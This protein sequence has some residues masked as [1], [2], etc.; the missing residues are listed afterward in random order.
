MPQAP[1]GQALL[2]AIVNSAQDFAIIATDLD[3]LITYWS[4]GA[5]QLLGW[6]ESE[7]IGLPSRVFF[8]PEDREAGRPQVEMELALCDGRAADERWHQRRD[9]SQF[10]GQ[11][12]TQPLMAGGGATIGFL[13]ILRDRTEQYL[14]QQLALMHDMP[15]AGPDSATDQPAR[16]A[17]L[18]LDLHGRIKYMSE[19][20][21]RVVGVSEVSEHVDQ[22]WSEWWSEP[23]RQELQHAVERA[24]QGC[25]GH[26]EGLINRAEGGPCWWEV[27]LLPSLNA[28]GEPE[29]IIAL[30]QDV[31]YDRL[32]LGER[33][34]QPRTH[35]SVESID[36]V[37]WIAQA[38][39]EIASGQ[40]GWEAL[41]GQTFEQYQGLGWIS[42]IHPAD[43]DQWQ[44]A[45]R[46]AAAERRA[47]RIECR[48]RRRDD[49]WSLFSVSATPQLDE[50]QT[51][52]AWIIALHD[53][54][55]HRAIR[56]ALSLETRRLSIINRVGARLAAELDLDRLVQEATDAGVA[57]TAAQFGSFFYNVVDDQGESYML[58]ALSGAARE[59]FAHFPM[60]RN[61]SVFSATFQG[62]GVLRSD[63]I[64]LDPR[65]GRNA[66]H[67]GMP[68]GHL[69]VRSYLAVP[70]VSRSGE[71]LGGMLFGHELAGIFT[72][73]HE[74]LLVG[75]AGQ[76]AIAIDNARLFRSAQAEVDQRRQA[77]R[78]MH[79]HNERLR[80]LSAA[81]ERMPSAL[82]LDA[83]M[84]VISDAAEQIAG[85]DGKALVLREGDQSRYV[86]SSESRWRGRSFALDACVSGLAMRERQTVVVADVHDDPRVQSELYRSTSVRSLIMVPILAHGEAIAAIG[87]FWSDTH[88]SDADEV[89]TLE[90]MARAAGSVF[91][92]LEAE[93]ALRELNETLESKVA[94]RTADR[95]RMWRLSTDVMMVARFDGTMTALNPAWERVLGW[96]EAE[97][98]GRSFLSLVHP[99][100]LAVT[101]DEVARLAADETTWRFENRYAHKDGSHRWMSWTA[102]PADGLIQAVARDI[103]EEKARSEALRQTEEA[104]RQA[105]K[106]EAVGQLTGGIA[107]DF[108]N[109]LTGIIGSL[110]MMQVRMTQGRFDTLERYLRAAL[111]SANRAG[112][113]TH[114]LLAF[115]R[116]Q[117]LAPKP[118][119]AGKL[120]MSME[121]LLRRTLGESVD[122]ELIMA[123]GL[124]HALCDPHQLESAILNLAINARDAMPG[125]GKLVIET[126]NTHLDRAYV[127]RFP[128][129]KPGQYICVAVTDTGT[130]MTPEV[131]ERAFEPFFT[132][133]PAGQGT[134]LGLSMIYGFAQQSEGHARIY[135]EVGQ[136]ST[137]KLYLPRTE[138]ESEL[139]TDAASLGDAYRSLEGE[140]VLVVEDEPVVQALVVEVLSDLGYRTLQ[141]ADG[142]AGLA[143]MHSGQA[144][145]LL[146]TDMG[147]PGLN[148][149]E[150]AERARELR[151]EL[152]VLFITGYAENATQASGFLE[153]G[154]D[155]LT[156]PFSIEA[157]AQRVREVTDR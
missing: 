59:A 96:S 34:R 66:P 61:T 82:S 64:T 84:R 54:S 106:M 53:L 83:L 121:E 90:A 120:V 92:R 30:V 139:A 79:L 147:L 130:G 153:P 135:S 51:I 68:E 41:T 81:I 7:A 144:I 8:T 60:P 72:E 63:D 21:K 150:L 132:T 73:E 13:K 69:P 111:G 75:I 52:C 19:A 35:A 107:H 88:V 155:M 38:N 31:T 152:K 133:K 118:V 104:L 10:W 80:L 4:V 6:S 50:N 48:I 141:A 25:R 131:V 67:R 95:D 97:L 28:S 109:L 55:A 37:A 46:S 100:D 17:P 89:A 126:C 77:E 125:G 143:V 101:R 142:A 85:A 71:V 43:L 103:T 62:L 74:Q 138:G 12:Q 42:A 156:K 45:R 36:S 154:S 1:D 129:L 137:V 26:F 87:L 16:G 40:P 99:D 136:G 33:R 9:G 105:Q 149:R 3:G 58:Y 2:T 91:K 14:T 151:P 39:G 102:V 122:L 24:S 94:E 140:T 86:H 113:L 146:I 18:V 49:S 145:D 98:A 119:D 23:E 20:C 27:Q 124:W 76:A 134:G 114:R 57:L 157:F 56:D 29:R 123:G 15:E 116:R 32:A 44:R 78:L 47:F 108:N 65:Y 117:P 128:S 5:A 112:T 22:L 93:Q 11:G 115:A 110:D 127:A 70:V 148:G